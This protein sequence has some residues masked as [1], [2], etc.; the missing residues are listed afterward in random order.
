LYGVSVVVTVNE[1]C[2][3]RANED[4]GAACDHTELCAR[5]P[6]DR[7][8]RS[9]TT[10]ALHGAVV[11]GLLQELGASSDYHRSSNIAVQETKQVSPRHFRMIGAWSTFP[12]AHQVFQAVSVSIASGLAS[13]L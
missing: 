11:L 6:H 3:F 12:S 10:T 4:R 1:V 7:A 5:F 9:A 13:L 2:I 8:D